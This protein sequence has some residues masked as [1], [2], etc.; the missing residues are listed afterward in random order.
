M[1]GFL[2][3]IKERA[4]TVPAFKYE[5]LQT[6]GC[7]VVIIVA[8][9]FYAGVVF[10]SRGRNSQLPSKSRASG[11]NACSWQLAQ[12]NKRNA[13]EMCSILE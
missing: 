9:A 2:S 10:A 6:R 1:P 5:L 4:W 13:T 3:N 8:Y 7:S 11:E 12:E